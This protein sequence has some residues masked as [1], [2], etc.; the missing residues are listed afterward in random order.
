MSA[1]WTILNLS[2]IVVNVLC[3]G[4]DGSEVVEDCLVLAVSASTV[5]AGVLRAAGSVLL[6]VNVVVDVLLKVVHR[7]EVVESISLVLHHCL[8]CLVLCIIRMIILNT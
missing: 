5:D 1:T 4:V 3:V 8:V 2:Y 6:L 7:A